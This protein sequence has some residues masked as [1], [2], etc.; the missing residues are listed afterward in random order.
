VE[1]NL[2]EVFSSIQGEGPDV[3]T[4]T[5]FVRFG[6]C[7]LRCAWC[8]SPHT[9]RPAEH[10]RLER[11]PGSGEFDA[12]P[13]P[14]QLGDLLDAARRLDVAS[15]RFVSLTGGEPLL[16]PAAA[17]ACAEALRALGPQLLL[18]T[19]G[20]HAGALVGGVARESFHPAHEAFL[21]A[22]GPAPRVVVKIVV[23]PASGDEEVAEACERI[24]RVRPD[25][26]L[27]LQPVTPTGTVREA[28]TAGRLHALER[29][30]A[31]SLADVRVIPQTHPQW[32]AL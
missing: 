27:V 15:H 6:A 22:A 23:T 20:L 25:A 12:V 26:C 4:R 9:W 30:A 13:N 28:P 5:L 17:A 29:L 21:R 19:H 7:D 1:A 24:A 3:G 14:L 8:D 32:G 31:R 2:V 11:A 18:E 16:Q 10:C